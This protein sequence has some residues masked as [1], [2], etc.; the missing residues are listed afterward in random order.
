MSLDKILSFTGVQRE[1]ALCLRQ[2]QIN[3][4]RKVDRINNITLSEVRRTAELLCYIHNNNIHSREDFARH[5]NDI[6]EKADDITERYKKI[7]EKLRE[8]EY[9]LEN[10]MPIWN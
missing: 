2:I 10:G 9:I 6:A 5:V 8:T 7:E 3:L 4:Y 1:Y